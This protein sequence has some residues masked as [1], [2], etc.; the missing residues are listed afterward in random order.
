[1]D[2][3]AREHAPDAKSTSATYLEMART[4]GDYLDDTDRAIHAAER[5]LTIAGGD[6]ALRL[7]LV[8][9]LRCAS[10]YDD[11]MSEIQVLVREDPREAAPWRELARLYEEQGRPNGAAIA[12]APL[13]VLEIAS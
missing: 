12:L 13:A 3:Y 5:G 8:H 1:L 2:C 11:A 6:R 4:L 7:E 10:R 9:R